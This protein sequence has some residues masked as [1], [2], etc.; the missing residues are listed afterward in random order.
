VCFG[1]AVSLQIS[2]LKILAG[3]PDGSA[4]QAEIKRYL[5]VLVASG[6]EWTT[7]MK[8]LSA[9]APHIDI[10]GQ[11]LVELNNLGWTITDNGRA[12]LAALELP[13]NSKRQPTLDELIDHPPRIERPSLPRPLPRRS[14]V[15]RRRNRR[16]SA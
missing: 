9:C 1:I 6:P 10:F 4:S 13:A 8:R 5:A 11:H 15:P 3:Q 16:R 2:I 7:R 14:A 12:F